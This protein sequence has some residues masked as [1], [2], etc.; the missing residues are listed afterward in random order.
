[1][2]I[3]PQYTAQEFIKAVNA[4]RLANK[5]KWFFLVCNVDGKEVGVKNYNTYLQQYLVDGKRKESGIMDMPINQWK[6][7]IAKGIL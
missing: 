7:E 1:M 5:G 6:E 4:L 3:K 2:T